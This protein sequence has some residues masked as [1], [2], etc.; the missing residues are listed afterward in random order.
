[1][2][3]ELPSETEFLEVIKKFKTVERFFAAL[4]VGQSYPE[5]ARQL[6]QTCRAV[7]QAAQYYLQRVVLADLLAEERWQ[8]LANSPS[9]FGNE[10]ESA[11]RRIREYMKAEY[12]IAA[13]RPTQN[14][15]RDAE[16]HALH[17]VHSQSFGQIAKKMHIRAGAAQ[18]GYDRYEERRRQVI[19]CLK[20]VSDW[21]AQWSLPLLVAAWEATQARKPIK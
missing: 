15:K 8:E 20:E 2:S 5:Q 14:E 7:Q 6:Q 21:L 16:I 10:L 1:M 17:K 13:H 18:R 3:S 19:E 12:G 4:D 11:L 9:K